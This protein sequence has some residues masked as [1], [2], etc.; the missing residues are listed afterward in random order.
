[1]KNKVFLAIIF[2]VFIGN[3]FAF[4]FDEQLK[5]KIKYGIISAGYATLSVQDSVV[6]RNKKCVKFLS[7]TRTNSTFDHIFKVRD[8]TES[9]WDPQKQISYK[10]LKKLNEGKYHQYRIHLYYPNINA[11]Y[12]LRYSFKKSKFKQ[13]RMDIPV[14][15]QDVLSAFYSVREKKLIPGKKIVVN[16]TVDG[17]NYPATILVHKIVKLKTMYGKIE[18]VPIEPLLQ[19]EAVFKQNGKILIYL[20]NDDYKLPVLLESKVIFGSF[21]AVLVEAKNVPYE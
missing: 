14:N 7:T 11:S 2:S 9:T 19:S 8:F 16:V 12:Y 4:N 1:L 5:F 3:I 18:C 6:Y 17:V 10:F 20:T 15:T 13:T 21:K